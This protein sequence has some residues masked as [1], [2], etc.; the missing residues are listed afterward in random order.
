M[1][2]PLP[3][4]RADQSPQKRKRNGDTQFRMSESPNVYLVLNIY[5]YTKYTPLLN[6]HAH[7][8]RK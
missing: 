3:K 8:K 7:I 2:V 5:T 4:S 6:S 1:L